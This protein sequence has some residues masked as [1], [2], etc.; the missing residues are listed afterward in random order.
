MS[1]YWLRSSS[2]DGNCTC[3]DR[4]SPSTQ[5]LSR[6]LCRKRFGSDSMQTGSS[7]PLNQLPGP[8]SGRCQL[9]SDPHQLRTQ[10]SLP[11]RFIYCRCW[12]NRPI[13]H[14]WTSIFHTG[15]HS[16]QAGSSIPYLIAYVEI[17][18]CSTLHYY[19]CTVN[20]KHSMYDVSRKKILDADKW[21]V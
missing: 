4:D 11:T 20:V 15:V 16:P 21:T 19:S 8:V 14:T 13:T 7:H 2:G 10:N 9:S 1:S 12:S 6:I 18:V 5:L 3:I 17:I